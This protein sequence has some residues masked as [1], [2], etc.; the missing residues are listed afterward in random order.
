MACN[1]KCNTCGPQ[2][3]I[4]SIL[5]TANMPV[6]GYQGF[7]GMSATPYKKKSYKDKGKSSNS[8]T[9]L[10]RV[11]CDRDCMASCPKSGG[12]NQCGDTAGQRDQTY[13]A[14]SN[15]KHSIRTS[16]SEKGNYRL[17]ER[18]IISR[19]SEGKSTWSRVSWQKETNISNLLINGVL[20][21]SSITRCF[22]VEE[23]PNTTCGYDVQTCLRVCA[24]YPYNNGG[25]S[26]SI[27]DIP[28]LPSPDWVT[29]ETMR[30]RTDD[31]NTNAQGCGGQSL[32]SRYGSVFALEILAER[33]EESDILGMAKQAAKTKIILKEE[34]QDTWDE[35]IDITEDGTC[36]RFIGQ[37]DGVDESYPVDSISD[38][39]GDDDDCSYTSITQLPTTCGCSN[40]RDACWG[41]YSNI[42]TPGAFSY[43]N[44]TI[45]VFRI[46]SNINQEEFSKEYK[47]VS[48]KVYFYID[49]EYEPNTSPCCT[50]C[51]GPEC[52]TGQ[53]VGE[54]SYTLS[55]GAKQFKQNTR[56]TTD[57]NYTYDSADVYVLYPDEVIKACYTIDS[58]EY[59]DSD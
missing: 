36:C 26:Q 53:I 35:N 40:D 13:S 9:H 25:C 51:G 31:Y 10:K 19:N 50:D 46:A 22:P 16:I 41:T 38:C 17:E 37:C 23:V 45:G 54:S 52:F 15:E 21:P 14:K 43:T 57:L 6:D 7:A 3:S 47:Y 48:G 30:T 2:L 18:V 34:N 28:W 24:D 11:I 55:A 58:V 39:E 29:E 49:S 1:K 56:I 44:V 12:F 27:G 59:A 32:N 42:A 4:F 20:D 5:V 8:L 33:V